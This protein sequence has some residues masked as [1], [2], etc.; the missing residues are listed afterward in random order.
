MEGGRDWEEGQTAQRPFVGVPVGPHG[1]I[2]RVDEPSEEASLVVRVASR[3]QFYPHLAI[4][5][6]QRAG[7]SA[8]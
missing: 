1:P 3:S 4:S 8:P 2:G 7:R 5:A 6:S